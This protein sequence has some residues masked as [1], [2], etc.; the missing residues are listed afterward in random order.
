MDYQAYKNPSRDEVLR[1]LSFSVEQ[2]KEILKL[3]APLETLKRI[4][5]EHKEYEQLTFDM[6]HINFYTAVKQYLDEY[7][8]RREDL[9]NQMDLYGK[10]IDRGFGSEISPKTGRS[11]EEEWRIIRFAYRMN[12]KDKNIF[13]KKYQKLTTSGKTDLENLKQRELSNA[14]LKAKAINACVNQSP[15]YQ[16]K[17]INK[18]LDE[19]RAYHGRPSQLYLTASKL[20]YYM[21]SGLRSNLNDDIVTSYFTETEL[22]NK[23]NPFFSVD[24]KTTRDL[25]RVEKY[26]ENIAKGE[27]TISGLRVS[28]F[29]DQP[30]F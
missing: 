19:F 21:A 16:Q 26:I 3:K 28:K 23:D 25:N 24:T 4:D 17:I 15:E 20:N 27:I 7:N 12:A 9:G 5:V 11:N 14:Q 22:K 2:Y 8:G 29:E 18:K 1:S 13:K 6:N 30:E 10:N